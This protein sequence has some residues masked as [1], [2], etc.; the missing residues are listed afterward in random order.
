MDII[1]RLPTSQDPGHSV[2]E[3][4][5]VRSGNGGPCFP[6]LAGILGPLVGGHRDFVREITRSARG[7]G[8]GG[9][10]EARRKAI[11]DER[12]RRLVG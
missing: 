3:S 7:Q 6:G 12:G 4:R 5:G 9:Q 11:S 8:R 10:E 1:R 2:V